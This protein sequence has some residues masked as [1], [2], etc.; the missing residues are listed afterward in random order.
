M[1]KKI[2]FLDAY[3][4]IFRAYYA[5]I[6]NPR[7][8]SKG[9]NTSAI[10]GFFNT[11]L[12][13]IQKEKPTH[14]A[15][16][17]DSSAKTFR[18]D[19]FA[20]YKA[21]REST[22]EDIKQS[23]P[24]IKQI[25]EALE[26]PIF[27]TPG[28]EADDVI[29]TLAKKYAEKDYTIFM[30]TSDK[31]YCQLV[32][33]NIYIYKPSRSGNDVE[34]LG[35]PEVLKMFEIQHPKQVIDVLGLWGDSSDN[36]P[37]APGIGEKT[38]KKL[39]REFGSIENLI[40]QADKLQGKI[41]ETILNH[42]DQILLSKKLV[43]IFT[44]VPIN[45]REQDIMLNKPDINKIIPLF[46]ELE[47]KTLLRRFYEWG[48]GISLPN[49]KTQMISDTPDLFNQPLISENLISKHKTLKDINYNYKLIKTEWELKELALQ[50]T[51][52]KE[53]SFDTETTSLDTIQP[54]IVGISFC[55]EPHKAYY[56]N[57]PINKQDSEQWLSHL[58]PIFENK[59]ILKIAQNL[60][61]DY[62]VLRYYGITIEP[63]V[64]DTM[65]AHYLIEPEQSH[66][67][68]YLA[69]AYLN[70]SPISFEQLTGEK[71][72]KQINLRLI[73]VQKL[74]DYC[75][76]DS[77]VAL[78]LKQ[79][80]L[81][82]LQEKGLSNLFE[83]VEMPLVQVLA[84]M[85]LT[86]IK[87]NE[88]VLKDL[89][90]HILTLLQ[91]T[92]QEIYQLSGAVFNINSPRQ[93]GE[94]LFEKMALD[95]N[96]KKTKTQ[97]Y[98]TG[99]E[100]LQKYIDRHPIISKILEYRSLQ[101]LLNTY[102][103]ALPKLIHPLSKKIHTSFSQVTTATGRLSSL[104]PN[105]Q[106][107][108]IREE[109]GREIRKAFIPSDKYHHIV[110]SDYSQIEL[111]I[112]AHLSEDENMIA[113]FNQNLDIHAATASRIF[114]VPV[115]LV[116]REMR[117][118]AKIANFGIIYGISPFG[119][120]QRLNISRSEAKQLIDQYFI[121]YPGVQQ[122]MQ[123]QIA[124]AREHGFVETILKR[125]RYLPDINSRNA[126]VRGFAERN[127][128]NAPIQ[129]SAAD[130]IKMAMIEIHRQLK[131]KSYK[132]RL[133]LQVHDELVFETTSDELHTVMNLIKKSMETVYTLRVPLI[134]EIGYGKN[135]LEAH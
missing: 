77:D 14:L 133:L 117:S 81:P 103:E 52:C 86:G 65:I 97:Q 35:I 114:G 94:I 126:V 12:D 55:T 54:E 43:T 34:I 16:A 50:L 29:G 24:Y 5:F 78:Q 119:L 42:K 85:E 57:L 60:K 128:I 98:A 111:R 130:I 62:Q 92:E 2:F 40:E 51:T 41:K 9:I 110:S 73:D 28:F 91:A 113:D 59:N 23:I 124:Y 19:M 99:E 20:A 39:I 38:A 112:M 88:T 4:L 36:I 84:E 89:S 11:L 125:R 106:N 105:L 100:E 32:D 22:P 70:Y 108:P 17:F 118:K 33:K 104:N 134:V 90:Q 10:F 64:F 58:K 72:S 27:E 47:F 45:I 93:L 56:I 61:F 6:K 87:L 15:V 49:S 122:Y 44:E 53:L 132:T 95:P 37:G 82:I 63:P 74:K 7:I 83:T 96:A 21:T 66:N 129:G 48:K 135:W 31:D 25:L 67:L 46:E 109:R 1:T 3:A 26:V 116:T 121:K 101:K 68:D 102:T 18:H 75:C 120:S 80:L 8:N 71:K 123:R 131:Q 115:E 76:E 107:I 69:K 127:A 13:V 30:M 79:A